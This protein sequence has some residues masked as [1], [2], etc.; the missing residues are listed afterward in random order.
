M[1]ERFTDRAR[2]TIAL[3]NQEAHRLGHDHVGTEHL[4]LGMVKE[5][6]GLAEK[7]TARRA[8]S[9]VRGTLGRDRTC[10]AARAR[11][12]GDSGT[13]LDDDTD[14]AVWLLR[15]GGVTGSGKSA[16]AVAGTRASRAGQCSWIRLRKC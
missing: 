1:F 7:T 11:T 8:P 9:A 14:P 15:M 4:L 3:A 6:S 13:D 2:R 12:S 16:A 10:S 5:R